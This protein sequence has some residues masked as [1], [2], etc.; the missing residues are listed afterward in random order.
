MTHLGGEEK[1]DDGGGGGIG[2][3]RADIA[4]NRIHPHQP[5]KKESDKYS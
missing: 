2:G 4:R 1:D 5:T 3:E